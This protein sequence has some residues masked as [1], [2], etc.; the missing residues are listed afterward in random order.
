MH[1]FRFLSSQLSAVALPHQEWQ[2]VCEGS[3]SKSLWRLNNNFIPL[4]AWRNKC[5]NI[6]VGALA[7][8]SCADVICQPAETLFLLGESV[9]PA[10]KQQVGYNLCFHLDK[11]PVCLRWCP[12]DVP[13]RVS[14][15]P[16]RVPRGICD[17][18][19][20]TA[21]SHH[22][23]SGW[24]GFFCLF[25]GFVVLVVFFER[26]GKVTSSPDTHTPLP[27]FLPSSLPSCSN[28][29]SCSLLSIFP[30]WQDPQADS[31]DGE[32]KYRGSYQVCSLG[33]HVAMLDHFYLCLFVSL[34][35]S[36]W[37]RKRWNLR[38]DV[39]MESSFTEARG[40]ELSFLKIIRSNVVIFFF[41]ILI[42][43]RVLH[44][45]LYNGVE[46][47]QCA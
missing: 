46:V 38:Q 11:Q 33:N 17:I 40:L 24:S 2:C 5:A 35:T 29:N 18:S 44:Q 14:Q 9:T 7:S 13:P 41:S 3:H 25:L 36:F 10:L 34:F 16:T 27:S 23:L 8:S 43:L 6:C 30:E 21:R 4:L 22:T 45:R 31:F 42:Y 26:E 19:S 15:K 39:A 47:V 1:I 20:R 12:D 32:V 37:R 28:G